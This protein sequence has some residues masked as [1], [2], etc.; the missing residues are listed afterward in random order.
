MRR[1]K[2]KHDVRGGGK[3]WRRGEEGW[4]EGEGEGVIRRHFK[5][6]LHMHATVKGEEGQHGMGRRDNIERMGKRDNIEWGGGNW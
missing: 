1:R 2:G 5:V 3:G 4:C 6:D